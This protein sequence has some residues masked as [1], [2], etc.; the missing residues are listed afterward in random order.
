MTTKL[1]QKLA[2]QAQPAPAKSPL[3]AVLDRGRRGD[4]RD[5]PGL[6]SV[7]L[8]LIG[9]ETVD[10]IE[11]AVTKRMKERGFEAESLLHA[12][13]YDANRARHTLAHAARDP[14]DRT[15]PFGT[16]AEWGA[17]DPDTV[18]AAWEAFGDVRIM[19]SPLDVEISKEARAEILAAISKKNAMALR[20][21]GVCMLS[22]FLLSTA[23]Q[24]ETSPTPTS[25]TGD[26]PSES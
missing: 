15:K 7:W 1:G 11:E 21:F 16:V 14:S 26:S 4:L 19:L 20:S 17:L 6:G 2:G 12:L 8:E 25:S 3:G 9:S 18:A 23:S 5:I 10:D 22:S 24:P 13:T